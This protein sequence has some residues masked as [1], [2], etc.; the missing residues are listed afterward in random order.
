MTAMMLPTNE[1]SALAQPRLPADVADPRTWDAWW[2][3][4]RDTRNPALVF[5]ELMALNSPEAAFRA[6]EVAFIADDI[7]AAREAGL[8]ALYSNRRVVQLGATAFLA[9]VECVGLSREVGCA[10]HAGPGQVLES[11][12]GAL[13]AI[14]A[15]PDRDAFT[16]EVQ[17]R[18]TAYLAKVHAY[19]KEYADAA[20]RYGEA[21]VMARA[22]RLE[23]LQGFVESKQFVASVSLGRL[24]S[25]LTQLP[26]ILARPGLVADRVH[27]YRLMEAVSLFA[28][29]ACDRALATLEGMVVFAADPDHVPGMVQLLRLLEGIEAADS[30]PID[31]Y[32]EGHHHRWLRH[33][34]LHLARASELRAPGADRA[35]FQGAL[36]ACLEECRRDDQVYDE[37]MTAWRGW[38]RG[39][40]HHWLGQHQLAAQHLGR[41]RFSTEEMLDLRLMLAALKLEVCLSP[42]ELPSEPIIETVNEIRAV[43]ALA[44]QL[45]FA[46]SNGLARRMQRWHPTA[47]AFCAVLPEPVE[48]LLEARA[49]ILDLRAANGVQDQAHGVSLPPQVVLEVILN[50]WGL[51]SKT[52]G[53][54]LPNLSEDQAFRR[55][56]LKSRTG[57][58]VHWRT[59]VS[60]SVLAFGMVQVFEA[61]KDEA[62]R[63]AAMAISLEF[64]VVPDGKTVL[65]KRELEQLR[66]HLQG[67]IEGR[68]TTRGFVSN[69]HRLADLVS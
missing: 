66:D 68:I 31:S 19:R 62:Y 32:I 11:V 3:N 69:I 25:S 39:L 15:L 45:S 8:K 64:G 51:Q 65:A 67:L 48:A 49:G 50:A 27:D 53:L 9:Y 14:Q 26:A 58:A 7:E 24:N 46:S 1:Y 28:L 55:N 43:F 23:Q 18:T 52:L 63:F 10:D 22:L 54:R 4:V 16:L 57:N 29:G 56:K 38:I 12:R 30:T 21:L 34:L 13:A 33:A 20:N 5:A 41:V 47:A 44:E 35:A 61:T 37:E 17:A 6:A 42:S 60:A 2:L 59:P 36:M 40:C